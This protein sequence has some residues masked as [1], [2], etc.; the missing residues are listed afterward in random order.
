MLLKLP[1]QGVPAGVARLIVGA[2]AGV[3]DEELDESPPPPPQ[4]ANRNNVT[5]ALMARI[6]FRLI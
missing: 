1:E 2:G 5:V 6:N 4:E 3:E